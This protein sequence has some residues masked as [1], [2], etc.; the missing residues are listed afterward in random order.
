MKEEIECE[1]FIKAIC[2]MATFIA[3]AA[4]GLFLD[5]TIYE[6]QYY[7]AFSILGIIGYFAALLF[8]GSKSR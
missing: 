2:H 1:A 8:L 6:L 4:I 7:Y 3:S 5:W